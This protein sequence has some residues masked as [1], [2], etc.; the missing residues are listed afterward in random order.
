MHGHSLT[1][2]GKS[3]RKQYDGPAM[4]YF[5]FSLDSKIGKIDWIGQGQLTKVD[6]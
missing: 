2:Q 6:F 5:S 1:P 4:W 3:K